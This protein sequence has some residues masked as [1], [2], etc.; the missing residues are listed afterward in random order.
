VGQ[1]RAFGR[2][3]S[4]YANRYKLKPVCP[5][6]AIHGGQRIIFME[7]GHYLGQYRADFSDVSIRDGRLFLQAHLPHS[8]PIE[9]K[10]TAKGPPQQ[11]RDGDEVLQFFR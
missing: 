1:V 6:C 10:F 9:V 7:R 11:Q 8:K 5:E 2:T 4:I 3:F